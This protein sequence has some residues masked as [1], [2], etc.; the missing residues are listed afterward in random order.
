VTWTHERDA[1]NVVW[2]LKDATLPDGTAGKA[3]Q[4]CE[5]EQARAAP[6]RVV[7]C[8]RQ[9]RARPPPAIRSGGAA[10]GA[11]PEDEPASFASP[12]DRSPE[13]SGG[14]SAACARSG[15]ARRRRGCAARGPRA[16]RPRRSAS[17]PTRGGRLLRGGPPAR[18][19]DAAADARLRDREVDSEV[20]THVG[21]SIV[22]PQCL[23]RI[24]TRRSAE[25][26]SQ[27]ENDPRK[28]HGDDPRMKMRTGGAVH[29]SA[30]SLTSIFEARSAGPGIRR[31][32][33]IVR[34]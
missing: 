16:P 20:L 5:I 7:N 30:S 17:R 18:R 11:P 24:P 1:T 32:A 23:L 13:T 6:R 31:N 34:S 3:G 15:A 21:R 4:V 27:D 28:I 12:M 9:R 29:R 33:C 25:K 22:A 19:G 10:E 26:R 8:R 2:L 14:R